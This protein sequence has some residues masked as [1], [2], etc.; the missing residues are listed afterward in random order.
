[1]NKQR[2]QW[3]ISTCHKQFKIFCF[4]IIFIFLNNKIRHPMLLLIL[5]IL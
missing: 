4:D 3:K 5:D 1:M 2:N